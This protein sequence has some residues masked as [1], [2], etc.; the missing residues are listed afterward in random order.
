MSMVYLDGSM[1]SAAVY[2]GTIRNVSCMIETIAISCR[3]V[4]FPCWDYLQHTIL[5]NRVGSFGQY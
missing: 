2:D 1:F 4:L 3:I 5:V